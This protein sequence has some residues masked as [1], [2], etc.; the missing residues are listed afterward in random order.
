MESFTSRFA[1]AA[2]GL[3]PE[4]RA[5]LKKILEGI[6]AEIEMCIRDSPHPARNEETPHR[7]RTRAHPEGRPRGRCV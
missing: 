7:L 1:E 5:T 2:K 6:S 3:N 4:D